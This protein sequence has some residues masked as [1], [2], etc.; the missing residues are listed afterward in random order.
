MPSLDPDI[1]PR[2]E[3]GQS[4]LVMMVARI[5]RAPIVIWSTPGDIY[6]HLAVVMS[7]TLCALSMMAESVNEHCKLNSVS[8]FQMEYCSINYASPN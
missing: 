2:T 3:P 7:E 5:R 8:Y 6:G 4:I 1:P